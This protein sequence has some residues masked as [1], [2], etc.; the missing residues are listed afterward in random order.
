M[1]AF[2]ED[3]LASEGAAGLRPALDHFEAWL[4][5]Q[6]LGEGRVDGAALERYL[7]S[8]ALAGANSARLDEAVRALKSYF[9]WRAVRTGAADP[10]AGLTL[11][12]EPSEEREQYIRREWAMSDLFY[13]IV[14]EKGRDGRA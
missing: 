1:L 8:L 11:F 4:Q 7:Y 10:A 9:A 3:F 14:P 12:S 6:G 5:E 13:G 2:R